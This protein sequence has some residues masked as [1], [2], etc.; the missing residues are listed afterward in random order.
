ME[1]KKKKA[2]M[3]VV[4]PENNTQESQKLTY[5]QLENVALDLQKRCNQYYSQLQS[6]QK[7]I[8]EFNEIGMMLEI[9]D[10]G[11][12]FSESFVTRC[13]KKV[14][15]IVTKALDNAE[16]AEDKPGSN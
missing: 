13:S 10:K 4:S 7:V 1:E 14:E 11:E 12:H 5:E 15:E 9:I 2:K 3:D 16:K 8:S 6:A